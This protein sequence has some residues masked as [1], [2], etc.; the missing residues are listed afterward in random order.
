M[1]QP[2]NKHPVYYVISWSEWLET[3]HEPSLGATWKHAHM[4]IDIGDGL[5]IA[6]LKSMEWAVGVQRKARMLPG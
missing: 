5:G 1:A 2:E 3:D 6:S 4:I